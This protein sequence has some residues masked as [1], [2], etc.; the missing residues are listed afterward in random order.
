MTLTKLAENAII[1]NFD[2]IELVD[3]ETISFDI[4]DINYVIK[5]K[6]CS[7]KLDDDSVFLVSV[8]ESVA[9]IN[10][11]KKARWRIKHDALLSLIYL[12]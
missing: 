5:L 10:I 2:F 6:G 12:V 7:M 3:S 1:F 4:N 9:S 8:N 11:I